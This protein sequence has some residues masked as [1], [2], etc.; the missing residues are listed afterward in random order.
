MCI[1][2]SVDFDVESV[3]VGGR[4]ANEITLSEQKE[5]SNNKLVIY[6][7]GIYLYIAGNFYY[8]YNIRNKLDRY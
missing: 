5:G 2:E 1:V 3:C 7:G 4:Y 6:S 8:E